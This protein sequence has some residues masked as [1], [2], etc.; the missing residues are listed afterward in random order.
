MTMTRPEACVFGQA[1]VYAP[2]FVNP[3]PKSRHTERLNSCQAGKIM[4]TVA[5]KEDSDPLVLLVR[6]VVV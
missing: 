6:S 1:K 3:A 5:L 4:K 2:G